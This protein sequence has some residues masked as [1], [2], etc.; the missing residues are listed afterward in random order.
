MKKKINPNR[1]THKKKLQNE[2]A[3][4]L[5]KQLKTNILKRKKAFK[6]HG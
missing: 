3:V 2:R 6:V 5:E 4:R 1:T